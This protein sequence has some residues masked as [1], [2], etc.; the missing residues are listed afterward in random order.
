MVDFMVEKWSNFATHHD[1]TPEDHE[2][3]AYGTNG[4]TYVR[5]DQSK[6]ITEN[7]PH[8]D[9]RLQFWKKMFSS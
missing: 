8:R 7:E 3:P 2:W 9:E 4:I 5:L 1:P 6:I